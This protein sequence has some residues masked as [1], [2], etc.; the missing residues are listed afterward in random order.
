MEEEKSSSDDG[1]IVGKWGDYDAKKQEKEK[2]K[3]ILKFNDIYDRTMHISCSFNSDGKLKIMN[4]TP[5][6]GIFFYDVDDYNMRNSYINPNMKF[7]RNKYGQI[8]RFLRFESNSETIEKL[9]FEYIYLGNNQIRRSTRFKLNYSNFKLE[10]ED[11]DFVKYFIKKLKE[12]HNFKTD[13][14]FYPIL[15]LKDH[16]YDNEVWKLIAEESNNIVSAKWSDVVKGE[17]SVELNTDKT[18]NK[19]KNDNHITKESDKSVIRNIN[20]IENNLNSQKISDN[21][22]K[23]LADSIDKNNKINNDNDDNDDSAIKKINEQMILDKLK[24][25]P[26]MKNEIKNKMIKEKINEVTTFCI[27][28]DIRFEFILDEKGSGVKLLY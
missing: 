22:N 2:R 7:K 24:N 15:E 1:E 28:N 5:F 18:E 19:I 26:T 11:N 10:I 16:K 6:K 17:K 27:N 14:K 3:M 25:V 23:N 12:E 4:T 20:I 13:F 21:P 8:M 9:N